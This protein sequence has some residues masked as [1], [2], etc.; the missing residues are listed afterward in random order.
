MHVFFPQD[1][2]KLLSCHR[3][4]GFAFPNLQL[5]KLCTVLVFTYSTC[6]YCDYDFGSGEVNTATKFSLLIRFFG[7]TLEKKS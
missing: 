2:D 4:V 3:A 5:E 6:K 1:F 7:Y